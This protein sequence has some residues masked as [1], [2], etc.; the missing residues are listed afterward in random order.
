MV[1]E[2]LENGAIVV[3]NGRIV[4]VA[5]FTKKLADGL[6]VHDAGD[7]AIFPAPIN[8]HTHLD[9]SG[10]S[11]P[12]G[13][14]RTPLHEWIP[15]V[16][17]SR[18]D[19]HST[20]SSVSPSHMRI[21]K[22]TFTSAERRS[23][24][25]PL[26]V[27]ISRGPS[28]ERGVTTGITAGI[29]ELTATHTVAF[30]DFTQS[31]QDATAFETSTLGGWSL[32]ELIGP[33]PA[34]FAHVLQTATDFLASKRPRDDDRPPYSEPNL[35]RLQ[36]GLAPHATY[37]VPIP[38]LE[39]I[40]AIATRHRALV[41]TH[42]AESPEESRFL[43]SQT[44]PFRNMLEAIGVS[45]FSAFPHHIKCSDSLTVLARA[46]R[47]LIVHGNFL[48]DDSIAFLAQRRD[49]MAVVHC[50]RSFRFF[51]Y[52]VP[53]VRKLRRAG[54][55]VV[56]GTDGR[57]STPSLDLMEEIVELRRVNPDLSFLDAI[58]MTTL[59]AAQSLGIDAWC[60]SLL[61][62]RIAK[63]VTLRDPFEVNGSPF[64]RPV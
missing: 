15:R 30:A 52:E 37:T 6:P 60:G 20:E 21:R 5:P 59:D 10:V 57:S 9:L 44:G 16:M 14:P 64:H 4:R 32:R 2:P 45:D 61:P 46:E 62:G 27:A 17:A 35:P 40:V 12:I 36:R 50:P 8:A 29:E 49:H 55:R 33:T 25:S 41:A 56:L 26:A 22:T 24:R 48:D 39:Q 63:F 43:D 34:R 54:V 53:I 1:G 38:L 13:Q 19:A 28:I 3:H 7:V 18:A 11:Q 31:E 51:G 58:Q 42:L 47:T 23:C